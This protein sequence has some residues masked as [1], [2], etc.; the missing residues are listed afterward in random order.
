MIVYS[1]IPV[2]EEILVNRLQEYF[3][4]EVNWKNAYPNFAFPRINNEFPWVPYMQDEDLFT[5]GWL[6]LNQVQE[7]LFPSIT[8]VSSQDSKSPSLLIDITDTILEADD[9]EDFKTLSSNEGQLIDPEGL[10]A[11]ETHFETKDQLIGTK[12][13]YQ[14][15]DTINIDITTDDHTNIKDRLYDLVTMFLVGHGALALKTDLEIGILPESLNGNRS[16]TYNIEFG[17]TLRGSTIQFQ[18]DYKIFQVYYDI[19]AGFFDSVEINH[20]VEVK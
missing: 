10:A 2:V 6:D 7:T 12:I 8:V 9:L 4:N 18:V 11:I 5:N 3:Q 14:R 19:D 13:S 20:T 17:R 1:S 15:R 16:G